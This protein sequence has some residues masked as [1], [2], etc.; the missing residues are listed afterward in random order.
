MTS[1]ISN[2]QLDKERF[3]DLYRT[4]EF[5]LGRDRKDNQSIPLEQEILKEIEEKLQNEGMN[6]KMKMMKTQMQTSSVNNQSSG[7]MTNSSALDIFSMLVLEKQAKIE[8]RAK[9]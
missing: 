8:R 1:L 9:K 6:Q 4:Y 5:N 7:K 3:S 2:Y